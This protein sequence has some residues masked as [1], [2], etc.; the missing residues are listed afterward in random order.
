LKFWPLILVAGLIGGFLGTP[1]MAQNKEALCRLLPAHQG[2]GAAYVPG[3]D[4]RGRPVVPADHGAPVP[5]I[6]VVRVPLSVDIAQLAGPDL[7]AYVYKSGYAA[8]IE[9][10]PDGRVLLDGQDISPDL[11]AVCGFEKPVIHVTGP[12]NKPAVAAAPPQ[13]IEPATGPAVMA[14]LEY[15]QDI[16]WG[17][18]Y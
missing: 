2:T 16:I 18:G 1:V 14:P 12:D 6:P 8:M 15:E 7:L 4:V 11:Y 17:E 9:I 3:V 10:H 5:A 13:T